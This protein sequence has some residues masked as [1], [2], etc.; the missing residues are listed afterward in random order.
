MP[1]FLLFSVP[2]PAVAAEECP[3]APAGLE[4]FYAAMDAVEAGERTRPL[5]VLHLG[6]S[7]ISNDGFTRG[8]RSRWADMF[9][10]AGRGLMPGVAF[11]YYKPDGFE[12]SMSGKWTVASSLQ[13]D[14]GPYGLQGFRASAER[15]DAVFVARAERAFASVT[16]DVAGGPDTG[17]I[18]LKIGDAAPLRLATRQAAPGFIRLTVPA[19]N[20]QEIRLSPAGTG[21]V[22]LLGWSVA[23]AN[24]GGP[25][26][27]YDS[28]G[29]V[30][31][32]AAVT[33]R[34]DADIVAAQLAA[35]APDLVILGYGTNEGFNNG[36]D[37][38]AYKVLSGGLAAR[39]RDA[40]PEASLVFLGPF[41]GARRGEG[42][43]CG[44]GWAAPPK[45]A[46]VR[47]VQRELAREKSGWFWDGAKP[48]G[49]RCGINEWALADPP[50]AYTDRV[51]IRP[52][53]AARLSAALWTAL[54]GPW[55][56][57]RE[58]SCRAR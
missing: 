13:A 46:A 20:V 55:E 17:A 40:A 27:R 37:M 21:P 19:A 43:S 6:D 18:A 56:A 36:L 16:L 51:H 49:G 3:V 35:L 4:R 31:A 53:G 23:Y 8:L 28:Y 47:D 38:T 39:I 29:I 12:L 50:L 26:L 1:L 45:L 58:P 42:A 57:A 30:A 41:D 14:P 7:H 34:W 10:D 48:M 9:G 44:G 24:E 15:P 5:V 54:M 52:A 32:T 11:T 33:Q 25:G 2:F 22:H